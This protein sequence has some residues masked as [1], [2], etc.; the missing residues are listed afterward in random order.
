MFLSVPINK[1]NF[2]F[3]QILNN[4]IFKSASLA[5]IDIQKILIQ[6]YYQCLWCFLLFSLTYSHVLPTRSK[7]VYKLIHCLYQNYSL[8][9][10]MCWYYPYRS[11]SKKRDFKNMLALKI[12]VYYTPKNVM[13]LYPNENNHIPFNLPSTYF[14]SIW[15]FLRSIA[16]WRSNLKN[17]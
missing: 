11:L 4:I 7:I 10:N 17:K 15:S 8:T 12:C 16:G 3:D 14:S 5:H 2:T 6:I 1:L 9:M 13:K